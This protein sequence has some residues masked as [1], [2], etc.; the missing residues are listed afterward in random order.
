MTCKLL[1]LFLF[2]A[3]QVFGVAPS[4]NVVFIVIDNVDFAYMG[5]CYGG[6]GL[7]PN[8]DR[9]AERGVLFKRAYATTPL[10]VPSRYTCLT[11]RYASRSRNVAGGETEDGEGGWNIEVEKNLPNLPNVMHGA[12][13]ATGFVGKFH[14]E[15][16]KYPRYSGKE[17]S[18]FSDEAGAW[19]KTRQDWLVGRI[20]NLKF[21]YVFNAADFRSSQFRGIDFEG[22]NHNMEADVL[23]ALNF[24]GE[25]KDKPFFLYMAPRLLHLPINP[26]LLLED[27]AKMG[28][29]TEGGLLPE[30]PQVPMPSRAALHAEA[31]AAGATTAQQFGMHWLDSGIGAVVNRLEE[32]KILD[33][34]LIIVYSDN[35]QRGKETLY[36]G[37]A[38]VPLLMM[39]PQGIKP[40]LVCDR[41]V[42]NTDFVPTILD[43]C[44]IQPPTDMLLDGRSVLPVLKDSSAPWREALLLENGHTR[45]VVSDQ[46]KYVA[47]RYPPDVQAKID[48]VERTGDFPR[49]NQKATT[50]FLRFKKTL[51]P[52]QWN[53]ARNS[54]RWHTQG[55]NYMKSIDDFPFQFDADQLF[56]ISQSNAP[57]DTKNV[58]SSPENATVLADMKSKLKQL[59]EPLQQ[60]FG[61][62]GIPY[63]AKSPSPEGKPRRKKRQA[64]DPRPL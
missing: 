40:G 47:L 35:N 55:N 38:R 42:A 36:E 7:T 28:R 31:K 33:N 39:W 50:F 14:L 15:H 46:W 13:Y 25:H 59:M 6:N 63:P 11:G 32:L 30:A 12:G 61:E 64:P 34:T 26:N 16:E 3:V 43:A 4:P 44:G 1:C 57:Q 23:G 52:E 51:T 48:E 56:L 45:G 20:Q 19:L 29:V 2:I 22:A 18:V 49:I 9:M 8:M 27:Y 17:A 24:I 58:A 60:P 10:C 62:F 41:I 21:D 53:F 54:W 5:K 37:G